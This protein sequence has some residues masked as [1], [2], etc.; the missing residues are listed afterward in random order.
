MQSVCLSRGLIIWAPSSQTE[1]L[2]LLLLAAASARFKGVKE[3]HTV[4]CVVLYCVPGEIREVKRPEKGKRPCS[5][6]DN[7]C[8]FPPDIIC[9]CA[10]CALASFYHDQPLRELHIRELQLIGQNQQPAGDPV[11]HLPRASLI[12]IIRV[13][14]AEVCSTTTRESKILSMMT[15]R[16]L[17]AIT[18]NRQWG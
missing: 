6:S 1:A 15:E 9:I 11:T 5:L 2:S 4:L 13:V 8:Y 10:M 3:G 17:S 14:V 18:N 16:V 7:C 12:W